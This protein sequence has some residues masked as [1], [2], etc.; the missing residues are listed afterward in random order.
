MHELA[1]RQLFD[2]RQGPGT[3][4][5]ERHPTP[6]RSLWP[7]PDAIR[8]LYRGTVRGRHTERRFDIDKFPRAAFGA[9]IIFHF[10]RDR[11]EVEPPHTTL[12]PRDASR[13]ASPLLLRPTQDRRSGQYR[14][15]AVRLEQPVDAWVLKER[16][17]IRASVDVDLTPAEVA[18]LTPLCG[19]SDPIDAYF[20]RLRNA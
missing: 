8:A 19:R 1:L 12:V 10:K 20:E 13:L 2:M 14:A 11:G 15:L 16:D 18:K 7:E 5:T 17:W 6:G 4:R 9:P 3:G